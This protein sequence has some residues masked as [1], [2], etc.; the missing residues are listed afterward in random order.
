MCHH[1]MM[2]TFNGVGHG[3]WPFPSIQGNNGRSAFAPRV[4]RPRPC[5][6]VGIGSDVARPEWNHELNQV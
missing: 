1:S 2:H 6:T 5:G 3:S 4:A